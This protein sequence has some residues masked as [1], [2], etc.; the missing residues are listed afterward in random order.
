MSK[1][2]RAKKTRRDNNE[3]RNKKKRIQ[4]LMSKGAR[5]KVQVVKKITIIK[6]GKKCLFIN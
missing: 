2:T 5:P 1:G 3:Q 4:L 6:G